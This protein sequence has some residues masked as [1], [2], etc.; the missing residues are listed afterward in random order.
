MYDFCCRMKHL[1]VAILFH[2]S[3]HPYVP[4]HFEE[5]I[6][7]LVPP[8]FVHAQPHVFALQS[9]GEGLPHNGAH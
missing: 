2:N 3:R 8:I 7:P 5:M 4:L 6:F 1:L 9:E